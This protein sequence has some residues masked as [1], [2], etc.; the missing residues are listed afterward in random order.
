VEGYTNYQKKMSI[1][2]SLVPEVI[3]LSNRVKGLN[4]RLTELTTLYLNSTLS[5]EELTNYLDTLIKE[6]TGNDSYSLNR[7]KD[8]EN[9]GESFQLQKFTVKI[10]DSNLIQI[11][12][13]LHALETGSPRM[14]IQRAE[15]KRNRTKGSLSLSLEI[16]SVQAESTN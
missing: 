16:A 11:S 15:I 8:S 9:I 2:S 1:S 10:Q 3:T 4:S 13:L 7:S 14:F 12:N 5:Y 6:N